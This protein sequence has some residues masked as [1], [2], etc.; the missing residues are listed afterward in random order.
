MPPKTPSL[1]QGTLDLIVLQLLRA[2][3]TNGYE[4]AQRIEALSCDVLTVNAGSLYPALYRLEGRDLIRAA[5][6]ESKTGR[7]VKV[8][9][10]TAAGRKALA[11]QREEWSRF[12]GALAAILKVTG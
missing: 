7:R 9:S 2:E 8:Y 12:A 6:Q 3:P 10:L 11:E 1:L 5:W 4:L